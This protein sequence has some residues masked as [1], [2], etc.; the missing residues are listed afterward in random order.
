MG[1]LVVKSDHNLARKTY[2]VLQTRLCHNT[3]QTSDFDYNVIH[4]HTD[5]P[6]CMYSGLYCMK[7]QSFIHAI[8]MVCCTWNLMRNVSEGLN[9]MI[10]KYFINNVIRNNYGNSFMAKLFLVVEPSCLKKHVLKHK[11]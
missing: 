7:F 9:Y 5:K 3:T 1:F 6:T 2:L 10:F 4:S 11:A 8:I